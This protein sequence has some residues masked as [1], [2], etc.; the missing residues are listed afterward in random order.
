MIPAGRENPERQL[1]YYPHRPA[2]D[3]YSCPAKQQMG[4]V[5][6][7]PHLLLGQEEKTGE[8][9]VGGANPLLPFIIPLPTSFQH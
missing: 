2:L 5:P 6:S 1:F 4:R 8:C 9:T 7:Y 3:T